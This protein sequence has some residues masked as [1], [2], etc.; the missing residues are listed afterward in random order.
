MTWHT[1][2]SDRSQAQNVD[3]NIDLSDVY[4]AISRATRESMVRTL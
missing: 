3:T 4:A 1:I 2:L